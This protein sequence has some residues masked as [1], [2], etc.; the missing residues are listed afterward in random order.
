MTTN[1]PCRQESHVCSECGDTFST[2]RGR[3]S[4]V[5][6]VHGREYHDEAVLRRLYVEQGL[7]SLEIADQYGVSYKTITNQLRR[8][9]IEVRS[10]KESLII[11]TPD[12]L[13]DE[14]TLRRLYK[15]ENRTDRE[16]S[17]YLGVAQVTVCR[18]RQ[19]HGIE[20]NDPPSGPRHYAW[21]P[22]AEQLDYGE[23]WD[24]QRAAALEQDDHTCQACGASGDDTLLDVHH[25]RPL[26]TFESPEDANTL[27]N[28]VVF[29]RSCHRKWEGIPLTPQ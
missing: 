29:C 9:G 17:E 18:W 11:D 22:D 20:A 8:H 27:D 15:E 7:S 23:N 6:Q 21:N 3:D 5:E 1:N 26:K 12:E 24:E 10:T 16:L 28:L 14:D 2:E 25:I 4:H 13:K 19:R